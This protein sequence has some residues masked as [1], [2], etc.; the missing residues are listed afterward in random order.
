MVVESFNL[1]VYGKVKSNIM[2]WS[3]EIVSHKDEKRIAIYFER[4][5]QY[6]ARSLEE[7]LKKVLY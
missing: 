1:W 4:N 2:I 3:A 7:V 5:T 6:S